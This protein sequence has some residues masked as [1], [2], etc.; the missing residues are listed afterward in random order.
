[1]VIVK[2]KGAYTC[3]KGGMP[4]NIVQ[5]SAEDRGK[6]INKLKTGI[7]KELFQQGLLTSAELQILA[8]WQ[9]K[10]ES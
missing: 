8:E 4:M 5:L 1:M 6:F 10:R 7:Y 2:E 9:R 3:K